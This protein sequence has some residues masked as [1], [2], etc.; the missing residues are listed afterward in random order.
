[1]KTRAIA[2]QAR[3]GFSTWR[4]VVSTKKH[5]GFTL[6]EVMVVVIIIGVMATFAGLSIGSRVNEDKLETEARRAEA[7]LKLASEEAEAKGIEIGLR[8]TE[9]GYRL[10][11]LDTNRK[12]QDYEASGPLR[13]RSFASP[14]ALSLLVDGRPT[15]LQTPATPRGPSP[16]TAPLRVARAWC[17]A[18]PT[19]ASRR[20]R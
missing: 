7:I 14:F 9:G 20:T 5:A 19:R 3:G 6:V 12:W 16:S 1:M 10:L 4:A 8:F 11:T 13:R 2:S 18:R 17:R 15:R